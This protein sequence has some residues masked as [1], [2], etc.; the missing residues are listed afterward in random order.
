MARRSVDATKLTV[1][2]LRKLPPGEYIITQRQ[3]NELGVPVMQ[4]VKDEP[5][6]EEVTDPEVLARAAAVMRHPANNRRKAERMGLNMSQRTAQLIHEALEEAEWSAGT[7]STRG[8]EMR[9]ARH[10]LA[11]AGAHPWGEGWWA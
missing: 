11:A 9:Q 8:A 3:L 7:D 4:A 2:Q 1:D 10:E 6:F 5:V